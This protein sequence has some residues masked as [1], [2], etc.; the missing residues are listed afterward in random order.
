MNKI[1]LTAPGAALDYG[2]AEIFE[3]DAS[4]LGFT[5]GYLIASARAVAR[6]YWDLLGPQRNMLSEDLHAIQTNFSVLD[7]GWSKGYI[8]YG[9]GIM[10]ENVDGKK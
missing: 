10:V 7:K 1:G 4:I 3:Q 2:A 6:F 8:R 9:G 5:C